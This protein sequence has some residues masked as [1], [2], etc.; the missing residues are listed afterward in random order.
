VIVGVHSNDTL[1]LGAG[2][3][4]LARGRGGDARGSERQIS[5][6]GND[7]PALRLSTLTRTVGSR[8][9]LRSSNWG[10]LLFSSEPLFHRLADRGPAVVASHWGPALGY[11]T[12][13]GT[14]SLAAMFAALLGCVVGIL[15]VKGSAIR[16]MMAS[17]DS[18]ARR[19]SSRAV[20]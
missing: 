3:G 19:P 9:T 17:T 16:A 12:S 8:K 15:R 2:F 11:E 18:D 5:D 10:T 7:P 13:V 4:C 6:I 1:L 20:A 14:A